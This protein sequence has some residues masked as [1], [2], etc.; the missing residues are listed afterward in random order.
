MTTSYHED[1]KRRLD[2]AREKREA[3]SAEA[4]RRFNLTTEK[5]GLARAL[6]SLGYLVVRHVHYD[7]MAPVAFFATEEAAEQFVGDADLDILSVP[8]IP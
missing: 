5:V 6:P 3:E 4:L 1:F 7:G 2:V 8:C